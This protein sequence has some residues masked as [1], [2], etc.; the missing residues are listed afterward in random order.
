MASLT[1]MRTIIIGE[2]KHRITNLGG[3]KLASTRDGT[4]DCCSSTSSVAVLLPSWASRASG[5]DAGL[6]SISPRMAVIHTTGSL[7]SLI[8]QLLPDVN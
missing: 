5:L 3:L 2:I 1:Q 4:T 6:L 7:V 8:A